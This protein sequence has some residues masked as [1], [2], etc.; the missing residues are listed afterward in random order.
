M[1]HDDPPS[2]RCTERS[3]SAARRRPY[4]RGGAD[5]AG[6]GVEVSVPLWLDAATCP[7]SALQRW[8]ERAELVDGRVFRRSIGTDLGQA[9]S[10]SAVARRYI[11]A[12]QR[13][14]DNAAAGLL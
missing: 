10:A 2:A 14:D 1:R 6:E 3:G 4:V 8:L 13:W 7:L 11:R 12:G 9:L 5:Q